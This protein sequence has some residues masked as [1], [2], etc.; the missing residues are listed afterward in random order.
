MTNSKVSTSAKPSPPRVW[1]SYTLTV[2]LGNYESVKID[3][4]CA[5]DLDGAETIEDGI[6]SCLEEAKA[7]VNKEARRAAKRKD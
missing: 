6:A 5:V 4:G 2:N 7:I 1:A 3:A